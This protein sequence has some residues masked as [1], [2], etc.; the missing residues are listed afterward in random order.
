MMHKPTKRFIVPKIFEQIPHLVAGVSPRHGGVSKTPYQSLNL[1]KHTADLPEAIEQNINLLCHELSICP[2]QLARAFQCHSDAIWEASN[3]DYLE[4]YDAIIAKNSGVIAGVGIAD[5]CPIL[6]VD[7]V[8]QLTA[9]IHAGWKG[10][11]ANITYKTANQL[12][13]KLGSNVDDLK[14][15]IGPCIS[16]R[17]FEVGEEVAKH[18][19]K[20]EKIPHG[21]KYLV[22]LK[23]AN[24]R[25]LQKAGITQIE[26]SPY[27]TIEDNA[28][29]F[30][31][32]LEKGTTGRMMA[33][34]GFRK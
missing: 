26:V 9:A 25:Q 21:E 11:A 27:C 3:G 34:A 19:E 15:W 2:E 23:K 18:F 8:K 1:G 22:D 5:C 29:F 13:N 31:H 33:F 28:M 17:H 30:S 14:A 10:T 20:E 12:I 4:N 16:V 7:P 32:R 6:I 24:E